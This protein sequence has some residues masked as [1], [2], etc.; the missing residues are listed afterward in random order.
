MLEDS[1]IEAEL[2]KSL[3]EACRF[4]YAAGA[5]GDGTAGH[6]SVRLDQ[7]RILIKPTAVSWHWLEPKDLVLIDFHGQRIDCGTEQRT[8]VREWPIHSQIYASRPDI[9]CVLHAHPSS[10]TLMAALN[11]C[12]EPL[13]QD[14][15]LFVDQ[16]PVLDNGGVSVCT[17]EL[18]DSV[19]RALGSAN[20]LLLKY[21]GSVVAGAEIRDV[22]VNAHKLEKVSE[23]MLRAASAAALPIMT[24][25]AKKE[26]VQSRVALSPSRTLSADGNKWEI[27][28]NY[29]LPR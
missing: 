7:T 26:V 19:A 24:Q 9:K 16:L 22:C 21:H 11:I 27:L 15:S 23:T 14:C 8:P 4:L 17:S 5:A 3:V 13:D 12:V 20:A 1:G 28:R 6:L 29:Y 25:S 2:R 18:G 10:S